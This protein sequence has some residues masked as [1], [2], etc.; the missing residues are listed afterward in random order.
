MSAHPHPDRL[1][2]AYLEEG[3]TVLPDRVYDVVRLEIERTRQRTVVVPW[4]TPVMNK[5]LGYGLAAAAVLV[6]AAFIGFNMLGGGTN[7]GGTPAASPTPTPTPSPTTTPTAEPTESGALSGSIEPGRHDATEGAV[8]FSFAVEQTGWAIDP[9]FG[10]MEKGAF[11][12]DAYRWIAFFQTFDSVA[13]NPCAGEAAVVGPSV[14]DFAT[15]MVA[16]PGT[17]A[18]VTDTTVGGLPAKLVVL[19]FQA[20]IACTPHSFFLYGQDSAYPESFDGM[21]QAWIVEVDGTRYVI[22][23]EQ[24]SQDDAITAE[25]R[26]IVD[27]IEFR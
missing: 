15:A 22:Q 4:R 11:G 20:D 9:A 24:S 5:F 25:T 13:T 18:E 3:Q 2:R 8:A 14:D 17:D 26:Q 21:I 27:S 1:I 6:V 10:L 7:S 16:I 23:T 19:T 12:T